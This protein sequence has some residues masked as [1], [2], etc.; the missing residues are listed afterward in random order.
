M[1]ITEVTQI[2]ITSSGE[3]TDSTYEP[4]PITNTN[5]PAAGVVGV[6]L[7][8]GD[9]TISVPTGSQGF[10]LKP[11]DPTSGVTK[12]LKHHSGETGFAIRTDGQA[13]LSLP[14]GATQLMVW[15]SAVEVIHIHWT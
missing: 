6:Q 8:I 9:N 12:R 7:A 2:T 5:G 15:A 13:C 4:D 3:G 10:F 1:P 11:V 14:T